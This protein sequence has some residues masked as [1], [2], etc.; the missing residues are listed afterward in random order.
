MSSNSP[1]V[2]TKLAE[3]IAKHSGNN[4]PNL[5][6]VTLLGNLVATPDIRYKTNPVS[7]IC[8]ITL[9]T[10]KKWLDKRTN[11][12]K[13]WTSFHHIMV[14]GDLVDHILLK[15]NK[16][17]VILV[18]GYLSHKKNTKVNADIVHA[19]F[20]EKFDKGYTESINQIQC[21]G[22]ILC[23]PKLLTTENNKKLVQVDVGINQ[24]IFSHSKQTFQT[25]KI[26]RPLHLWGKQAENLCNTA[27]V[28]D[29]LVI[30]GRLGYSTDSDKS[31]FIDGKHVHLIK[32]KQT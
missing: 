15:A 5:C 1:K 17:D 12:T 2:S 19:T 11:T 4:E 32:T 24:Y 7:A 20:I 6:A 18:H 14:E 8:E 31:Q 29:K 22:S 16:G 26:N 30:E 27:K 21:S 25:V 13:E 23:E 10:H 9:A 3:Q 28:D